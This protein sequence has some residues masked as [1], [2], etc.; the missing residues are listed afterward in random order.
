MKRTSI[1]TAVII[2][3]VLATGFV[4]FR[5]KN[6]ATRRTNAIYEILP[7]TGP[8]SRT[9]EWMLTKKKANSLTNSI[10]A[11]PQDGKALVALA[12]L[13]VQEARVTGNYSY[14]DMAAMK[15]VNDVLK[16]EP[17]NFEALTI[18]ALVHL[19]QHHFAEGLAVAE[20][21]KAL[22]PYNAFVYGI[23]VDANVELGNYD[24]AVV[25]CDKMVSIRPDL[26]SYS[27]VS[28]LREIHGD[29]AGA[30]EAMKMAVDAGLPGDESTEWARVQLG[31]LH[32]KSNDVK[33][34]EMAFMISLENR[35][36]YAPALV[37]LAGL[38]KSNKEY[39]KALA[40][41]MS[42]DTLINDYSIKSQM[43]ETYAASGQHDK[44]DELF[45]EVIVQME[46]AAEDEKKYDSFGHYSDREM[47]YAYLSVKEYD[48]ALFHALQ[49]Y[50]RRPANIDVNET[51]S[52]VYYHR[53][54]YAEAKK[55]AK[56][57]LSTG[58]KN[59]VLL[60]R[61]KRI[62]AVLR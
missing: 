2:L 39:D 10:K 23:M 44:A 50:N 56:K 33:N 28:Y 6:T 35:P 30:I 51:L 16:N 4:I 41:Y 24:T 12:A 45:K 34:A 47:A 15:Y 29:N 21:A 38:S 53:K 22:N 37:G 31:H 8:S 59:P 48:K 18:K 32:E 62:A 40:L 3:F 36:G 52:W 49:E 54:E 19:S 9:E 14:Y 55:Y 43:A 25:L 60:E 42:A 1:Y 27:R 61:A 26:R 13:F 7:R 11:N 58:C 17:G 5:Y 20:K 57:A 46:K